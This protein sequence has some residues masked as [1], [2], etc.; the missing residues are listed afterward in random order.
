MTTENKM[1]PL[2]KFEAKTIHRSLINAAPYN[3]RIISDENKK[4]LYKNL[5]ERGLL[6]TLVWNES[7]GNLV[8]GHQRL[9]KLDAYYDKKFKTF[10]YDLTVAA[11]QLSEKE[12]IEQNIF[13]NN[14]RAM[15]EF[16]DSLLLSIF[17]NADMPQIDFEL[18]GM[19][20]DDRQYFGVTLD[21][22]II[23]SEDVTETIRQFE[24]IKEQRKADVSPELAASRKEAVKAAKQESR[25]NEVDTFVTISFSNQSDK[26]AFM[27]RIGEEPKSL[28]IKG[29]LFVKKYFSDD[30]I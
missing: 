17:K 25:K 20:D 21:L 27:Q 22:D 11:V 2:Q 6:D 14:H 4:R 23:A 19:N 10:D 15:G 26:Q 3:P 5:E 8:S 18:A 13:F 12:E 1:H 16:E 29:E 28:Y 9:A 30:T 7:T 24:A